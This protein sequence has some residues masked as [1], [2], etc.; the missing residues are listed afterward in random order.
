MQRR[1]PIEVEVELREG[2][3][4]PVVLKLPGPRPR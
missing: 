3:E 2:E 4:T 1:D